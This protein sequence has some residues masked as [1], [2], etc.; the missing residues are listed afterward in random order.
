MMTFY[1]SKIRLSSGEEFNEIEMC[2]FRSENSGISVFV[3]IL[4]NLLFPFS[5]VFRVYFGK[6][7]KGEVNPVSAKTFNRFRVFLPCLNRAT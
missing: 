5:K 2:F 3:R 4:E 7:F 6:S 1:W